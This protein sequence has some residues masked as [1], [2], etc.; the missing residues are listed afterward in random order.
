MQFS[1]DS[2]VIYLLHFIRS[3]SE[4]DT[5]YISS[6]IFVLYIKNNIN[7]M[8]MLTVNNKI[9]KNNVIVIVKLITL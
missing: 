7:N 5:C 4:Y 1:I 2:Y 8:Y 9:E 3:L 6:C